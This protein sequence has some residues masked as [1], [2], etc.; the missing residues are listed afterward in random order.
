MRSDGSDVT[1]LTDG[2]ALYP[3]WSPTGDRIA[4]SGIRDSAGRIFQ[5]RPDGN[6]LVRLTTA[7]LYDYSPA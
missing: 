1:R 5:I 6:G 7:I 4:F 2:F 3:A